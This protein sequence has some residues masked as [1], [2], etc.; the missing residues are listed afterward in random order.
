MK[1]REI[2]DNLIIV[3]FFALLIVP[4]LVF[5]IYSLFVETAN[6]E[7][8]KLAEYPHVADVGIEGY[9]SSFEAYWND[10]IPFRNQLISVNNNIDYFV[11]KVPSNNMVEIGKN[12]WLFYSNDDDSNPIKQSLGMRNVDDNYLAATADALVNSERVLNSLGIE[13]VIFL[14]PNKATIY[15]EQLPDCYEVVN[16]V[17]SIDQFV[18]Y[19]RENT[20]LR[21]VYPKEALLEFKEENPDV[22]LYYKKDGHWNHAGGYIAARELALEL[23]VEM[24]RLQD[25]EYREIAGTNQDLAIT[26]N[27]KDLSGNKDY[28]ISGY[29]DYETVT[30]MWNFDTY[31]KYHSENADS[32]RLLVR[33]DSYSTA[34]SDYI[35]SQFAY[36]NM[37]NRYKFSDQAI[38]DEKPDIFVYESVERYF[39]DLGWMHFSYVGLKSDVSDGEKHISINHWVKTEN[40]PVIYVYKTTESGTECILEN[41]IIPDDVIVSVPETESGQIRIEVYLSSWGDE[42]VEIRNFSY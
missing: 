36:T 26:L 9:P 39:T 29:S 16:E 30:D 33:R 11:F 24:P 25:L 22:D 27:V 2:K 4:T 35:G 28:E 23:G 37:I 6:L 21:I 19:M 14:A 12:G 42:P 3:L 38:I 40:N 41:S 10:H 5:P 34:V 31:F 20:D 18:K 8:R 1:S 17:T 7:K 13:F 32:R 15:K